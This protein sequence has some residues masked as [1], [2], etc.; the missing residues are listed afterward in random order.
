MINFNGIPT[1]FMTLKDDE[2]L[3]KRYAYVNVADYRLVA[4]DADRTA[5][6]AAYERLVSP[7]SAT[8][9]LTLTVADIRDVIIDGNTVYYIRFVRPEGAASLPEDFERRNF[10][11]PLTLT[12]DL[13]FLQAGDTVTADLFIGSGE[14]LVTALTVHG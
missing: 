1:N 2:G 11:A 5:A 9:G 13:A 8:V 6:L 4:V 14:N 7:D 12:S 3:V 10:R